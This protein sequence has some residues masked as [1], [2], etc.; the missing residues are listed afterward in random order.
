MS[1]VLRG[2]RQAGGLQSLARSELRFAPVQRRCM[3][4]EVKVNAWEAPTAIGKWKEEHIV[5]LVLGGW[6]VG[7]YSAMK[8]FGGGDAKVAEPE[9]AA[10]K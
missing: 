2:L 6:G 8:V 4:D 10:A 5:F 3:S 1:G 9:A 7:I